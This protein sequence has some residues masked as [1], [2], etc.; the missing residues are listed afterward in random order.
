[1]IGQYT[2]K[3]LF[4][5]TTDRHIIA[6]DTADPVGV[7]IHFF[8][9]DDIAFSAAVESDPLKEL[10]SFAHIHAGDKL[11]LCRVKMQNVLFT[12]NEQD[13]G[14]FQLNKSSVNMEDYIA[15]RFLIEPGD[16][17][18]KFLRK[19]EVFDWFDDVVKRVDFISP[20]REIRPVCDKDDQITWNVL[21][22]ASYGEVATN[23]GG[24]RIPGQN[25]NFRINSVTIY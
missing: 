8:Q 12:L 16:R 13:L 24:N 3:L 21:Y 23:R 14:Y 6:S 7:R 4:P 20:D 19:R 11:S 18:V 15:D 5:G 17:T 22:R 1:M 10:F 2:H 25:F 9:V